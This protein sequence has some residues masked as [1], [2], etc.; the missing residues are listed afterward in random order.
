M[1]PAGDFD[2]DTCQSVG[3][4]DSGSEGSG[5]SSEDYEAESSSDDDVAND[6]D[7]ISDDRESSELDEPFSELRIS[8]PELEIRESSLMSEG[9]D[10]RACSSLE[11]QSASGATSDDARVEESAAGNDETPQNS[12]SESGNSGGF[13]GEDSNSDEM[14]LPSDSCLEASPDFFSDSQAEDFA[15]PEAASKRSENFALKILGRVHERRQ[16]RQKIPDPD[17][18]DDDDFSDDE[19][20][21]TPE[22]PEPVHPKAVPAPEVSNAAVPAAIPKWKFPTPHVRNKV[23]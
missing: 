21:E 19:S 12:E 17:D 10:E 15:A 13:G 6:I 18:D 7:D 4:E 3:S 9:S 8:D 1:P 5:S 22:D 14:P 11:L 20:P 23:S 16:L 2:P